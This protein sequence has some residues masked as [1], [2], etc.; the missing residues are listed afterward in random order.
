MSVE[1]NIGW[2][3]GANG[4]GAVSLPG[5]KDLGNNQ[6][7]V[8]NAAGLDKWVEIAR[9][10]SNAS[11]T[12]TN[13]IDYNHGEWTP[14][15]N[16]TGTFDGGE[17]TISNI[18]IEQ[19]ES[20]RSGLFGQ[21]SQGGT[22]KNLNVK[23]I[24]IKNTNSKSI[25]GGIAGINNGGT[26]EG[27]TVTDSEIIGGYCVGGIIGSN[28]N[29]GS[30]ISGC[31]VEATLSA[32]HKVGGIVGENSISGSIIASSY[33]GTIHNAFQAGG[34]I[35]TNT[36]SYVT[37]CWADCTLSGTGIDSGGV[38]SWSSG[39]TITACYWS[40]YDGNGI[41]YN[42][43][44][45]PTISDVTKVEGTTTWQTAVAGMN[46]ALA[47]ASCSWRWEL[48]DGNTYPTLVPNN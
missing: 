22:V 21:I 25:N 14:I 15:G 26:I 32:S 7:E 17:H 5:I 28:K 9:S 1:S 47:N 27:C 19:A 13:D 20:D 30:Q 3:D 43:I 48:L 2:T 10:N 23:N 35:G 46:A 24:T 12:L 44:E 38:A 33:K 31:H 39:G 4:T 37:A 29:D 40:G 45:A 34:I 16:Y 18:K 8:S 42:S 6:Y 11:C 41:G 36:S